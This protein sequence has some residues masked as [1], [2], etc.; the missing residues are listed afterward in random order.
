MFVYVCLIACNRTSDVNLL[1]PRMNPTRRYRCMGQRYR[2]ERMGKMP[3]VSL[4]SHLE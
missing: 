2:F 1:T 3:G 4:E